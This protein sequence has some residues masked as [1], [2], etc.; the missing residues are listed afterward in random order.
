MLAANLAATVLHHLSD[1]VLKE[2]SPTLQ[3][4][5]LEDVRT[6][7]DGKCM[8]LRT[9]SPVPDVGFCAMLRMPLSIIV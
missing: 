3:F 1:F 8:F 4:T 7:V 9:T 5:K 6:A 2:P